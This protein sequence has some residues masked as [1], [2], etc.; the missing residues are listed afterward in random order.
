RRC[1]LS[2]YR[3]GTGRGLPQTSW[4]CC[5][6]KAR[7]VREM[8]ENTNGNALCDVVGCCKSVILIQEYIYPRMGGLPQGEKSSSQLKWVGFIQMRR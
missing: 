1:R 5:L 3:G 2:Q 8:E 7:R 4:G 6:S